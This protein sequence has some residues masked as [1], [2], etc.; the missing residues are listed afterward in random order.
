MTEIVTGGGKLCP[1]TAIDPSSRR[2]LGYAMGAHRVADLVAAAL[3]MAAATR[4]GDVRG[5]IFHS[6]RGS[7][8][9]HGGSGVPAASWASPS[10]WAASDR[11][12]TAPSAR[13]SP[14]S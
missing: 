9:P 4:G 6:D 11:A 1:A 7:E 10:P 12:S 14:A 8:T 3:H 5:V 2:L 13:P